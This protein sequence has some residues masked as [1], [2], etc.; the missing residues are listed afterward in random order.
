MLRRSLVLEQRNGHL[1]QQG[2]GND[3]IKNGQSYWLIPYYHSG[4]HFVPKLCTQN[5]LRYNVP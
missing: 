3:A 1:R 2:L 4:E 5:L